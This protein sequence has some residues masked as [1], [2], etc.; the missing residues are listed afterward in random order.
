MRV[1][2]VNKVFQEHDTEVKMYDFDR[3]RVLVSDPVKKLC[4]KQRIKDVSP[5]SMVPR[6]NDQIVISDAI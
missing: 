6:E 1:E 4:L 5:V 2:R 3:M